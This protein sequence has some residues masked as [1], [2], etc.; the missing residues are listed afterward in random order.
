MANDVTFTPTDWNEGVAPGISA[1]QLDRIETG[2]DDLA[3]EF[4]AHNG[5]TAVTDHPEATSGVRGFLPAADKATIDALWTPPNVKLETAS[6]LAKTIAPADPLTTV[7]SVSIAVPA[8]W[9]SY[10]VLMLSTFNLNRDDAS[11]EQVRALL[12]WDGADGNYTLI[13]WDS[14]DDPGHWVPVTL[15]YAVESQTATGT[16]YA[17]L[18]YTIMSG[19]GDC[20]VGGA[21]GYTTVQIMRQT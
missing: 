10:D 18:K 12:S 5:G 13:D 2:V 14:S 11:A 9:N 17:R 6:V 4:S 7:Q 8:E 19:T 3:T 21:T 1:A 20:S 15:H 16:R